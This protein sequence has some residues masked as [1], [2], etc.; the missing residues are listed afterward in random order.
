MTD[1]GDSGTTIHHSDN[2]ITEGSES[3][4]PCKGICKK[5]RAIKPLFS[6]RY[7]SNQVRCQI[8]EIFLTSEG[9]QIKNGSPYC[10]CCHYRV[11]TKPRNRFY[12]EQ[13]RERASQIKNKI[14]SDNKN[15]SQNEPNQEKKSTPIYKTKISGKTYY[16]LKEFIENGIVPQANYQYVMLKYLI[17]HNGSHKGQI[18][19]SLAYYN[20][21]DPSNLDDV[22]KFLHVPV[23]DVLEKSEFIKKYIR[24]LEND[25]SIKVIYESRT[26]VAYYSIDVDIN[27]FQ[28]IE[29]DSLLEKKIQDWNNEHGISTYEGSFEKDIY[30]Y[31]KRYLLEEGAGEEKTT[32]LREVKIISPTKPSLQD[33][34]DEL[35]T[36]IKECPKCHFKIIGK[37]SEELVNRI[38]ESFGTTQI[39]S[40]HH[41]GNEVQSYCRRCI[42]AEKIPNNKVTETESI[43][44]FDSR[45]AGINIKYFQ[46]KQTEFIRK[47][48]ILTNDQ[49]VS[50]FLVGNMGGIRYSSKNN[51]IVLCDTESGH[52]KDII[53][54]EFQII[55]YT[56][57]GQSG[58]Q[59][60]SGG[61]LRIVHSADTP[62]FYFVENPQPHGNKVRGALDN[63]YTYVGKVKYIKHVTSSEKDIHGNSRQV[64]KFLLEI[65]K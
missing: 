56:G 45:N 31:D 26:N 15:D 9:V 12:K 8:C 5:Y 4:G 10:R 41:L 47:G 40:D 42:S 35:E 22:K 13:L 30:W 6:G 52:Y 49:L 46:L 54:K 65:E 3:G 51:L 33:E 27:E 16:E 44:L 19:E 62:M 43:T 23:Y 39:I 1:I 36:I 34:S 21:K 57:E 59:S 28:L 18:A 25:K 61:N 24:I 29:L 32:N 63:K 58:D 53:D 50:K 11:R 2:D 55:Y 38:Q 64:I 37:P 7:A 14:E 60:L 17:A 48:Q 20:G